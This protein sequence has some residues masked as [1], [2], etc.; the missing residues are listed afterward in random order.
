MGRTLLASVCVAGIPKHTTLP[1]SLLL[2]PGSFLVT[3][4][5]CFRIHFPTLSHQMP[6]GA[7]RSRLP[8]HLVAELARLLLPLQLMQ[9]WRN[10]SQLEQ[11]GVY[12]NV[13]GRM[14]A[15]VGS[16][17]RTA[18][19]IP[20]RS[21]TWRQVTPAAGRLLH[22]MVPWQW[23]T[24]S[25]SLWAAHCLFSCCSRASTRTREEASNTRD[26][27]PFVCQVPV[28]VHKIECTRKRKKS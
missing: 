24:C 19:T 7:A 6:A 11:D 9:G 1:S 20:V 14:E 18:K 26:H 10:G 25:C 15:Q 13:T 27:A 23:G 4:G 2:L 16:F 5:P 22:R 3:M 17:P 21:T 8:G 28:S 12:C